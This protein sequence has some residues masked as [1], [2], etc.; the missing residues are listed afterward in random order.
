MNAGE[1]NRDRFRAIAYR[2]RA[3]AGERYGLRTHIISR[4][5][6]YADSPRDDVSEK[7]TPI[8]EANG[9]P[10]KI[11]WLNGQEL[12]IGQLN[13][14]TAEVGPITPAFSGGG[15]ALTLLSGDDLSPGDKLYFRITGP[16]H[17]NGA[18]YRRLNQMDEK[19]LHYTMQLAPVEQ[20][21]T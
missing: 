18:L 12:T 13:P 14:G 15:T 8:V 9:Q 5:V 7:E 19:A 6:R 16:H 21:G 20:E 3:I 11:R 10:P 4:V 17:P 1:R 2:A